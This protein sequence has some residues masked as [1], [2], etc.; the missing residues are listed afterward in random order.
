M[1]LSVI[2]YQFTFERHSGHGLETFIKQ[3]AFESCVSITALFS[4]V[5]KVFAGQSTNHAQVSILSCQ[6]CFVGS[7][8]HPNIY[9]NLKII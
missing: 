4:L 1:H 6:F 8:E 3:D 2:H 5:A 9:L 7:F